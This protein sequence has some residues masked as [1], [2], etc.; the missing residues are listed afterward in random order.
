MIKNLFLS[1]FMGCFLMLPAMAKAEPAGKTA[2]GENAGVA[3][4]APA[5]GSNASAGN[6]A[7]VAVRHENAGQ[8]ESNGAAANLAVAAVP[9][10]AAGG[11][12]MAELE[13]NND[14]EAMM[15]Q[16][17]VAVIEDLK[18]K[19]F[20]FNA[21]DPAGN[22]VLYYLLTRNP[23]LAVAEKAI[24]YGADVNRPAANG[25]LPLNIAS[26]KANELQ[27][28]IMMMK[29]M[30]LDVS[31]EEVQNEL[32]KNLFHEMNRMIAMAKM[33]IDKGADVN[34]SSVLGTPLMNAVTNAWNQEIV[35]MLIKAGA[36]LDKTD[37]DGKTALFYA[38]ASGNDDIVAMLLA[39]GADPDIKDK[40]GKT[41]L[42]IEKINVGNIL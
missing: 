5:A 39:A 38:A 28:Q 11:N 25:M 4:A 19:N 7:A 10:P 30:G 23:D 12:V 3:A 32:K 8:N 35:D 27:L 20:D 40:N 31:N 24:E 17:D 37:A 42:E 1:I 29:A 2:V 34:Q 15:A 21:K 36:E 13:E 18:Q 9:F 16:A 14:L 41:Y 22:P 26:S 33:L 6:P